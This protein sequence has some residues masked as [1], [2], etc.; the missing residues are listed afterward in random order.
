MKNNLKNEFFNFSE[1]FD[2]KIKNLKK[3]VQ[4]D[5][6]IFLKFFSSSKNKKYEEKFLERENLFNEKISQL[7]DQY[8]KLSENFILQKKNFDSDFQNCLE[9]IQKEK[10]LNEKIKNDFLNLK[11]EFEQNK[12]K[13]ENYEE[14]STQQKIEKQSLEQKLEFKEKIF[15]EKLKNLDLL[16]SQKEQALKEN[17]KKKIDQISHHNCNLLENLKKKLKASLKL[18]KDYDEDYKTY[19]E[20][21]SKQIQLFEIQKKNLQDKVNQLKIENKDINTKCLTLV[22]DYEDQIQKLIQSIQREQVFIKNLKKK[23]LL[24]EKKI[25]KG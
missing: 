5:L 3:K 9:K 22:D 24:L 6:T 16:F 2:K 10:D 25:K 15:D 11:C 7:S 8:K 1:E 12:K 23:N 17:Q 20:K 18:L 4:N 19:K 13:L 21:V 14:I